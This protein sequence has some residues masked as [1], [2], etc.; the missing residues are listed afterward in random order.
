MVMSFPSFQGTK[1]MSHTLKVW[2]QIIWS[3]LREETV[4]MR[5]LFGFM[6]CKSITEQFSAKRQLMKSSGEE[7]RIYIWCSLINKKLGDVLW[8]ALQRKSAQYRYIK[9]I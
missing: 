5:N 8:E 2:E 1:S 3:R 6:T 9:I 7:E 4:I